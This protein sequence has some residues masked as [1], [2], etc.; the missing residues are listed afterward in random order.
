MKPCATGR[1]LG[2]GISRV[3]AEPTDHG[4]AG[5]VPDRYAGIS[6]GTHCGDS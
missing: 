6:G 5:E 3:V 4:R 2:K 1:A